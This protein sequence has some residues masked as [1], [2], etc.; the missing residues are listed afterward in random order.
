MRRY[1]LLVVLVGFVIMALGLGDLLAFA[2]QR[3]TWDAVGPSEVEKIEVDPIPEG[4]PGP[5]F[6]R[7]P[8]SREALPLKLVADAIPDPLPAPSWQ[9][10]RCSFGGNVVIETRGGQRIEYGP[11]RRPELIERLLDELLATYEERQATRI[12]R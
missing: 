7:R 3:V 5:R 4:P 8:L 12:N 11:C 6:A 2:Y 1:A 10:F 9:G